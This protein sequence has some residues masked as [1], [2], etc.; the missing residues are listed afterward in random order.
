MGVIILIDAM[1]HQGLIVYISKKYLV[2]YKKLGYDLKEM[3]QIGNIGLLKAINT[4]DESK[5]YKF[6]TYASTCI[7]NELLQFLRKQKLPWL[8]KDEH[9]NKITYIPMS[10]NDTFIDADGNSCEMTNVIAGGRNIN[11]DNIQLKISI[12]QLPVK[13]RKIIHLRYYKGINQR[14]AGKIMGISQSYLSRLERQALDKLKNN[15]AS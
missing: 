3:I 4:F 7:H 8:S 14:E 6:A 13:L 1:K 5:N 2:I 10:L 15:L 9:G 11:I 12:N